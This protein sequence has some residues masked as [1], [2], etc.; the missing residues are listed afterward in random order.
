MASAG[1]YVKKG[2]GHVVKILKDTRLDFQAGMEN[3]Q[4]QEAQQVADFEAS[5]AAYNKA[6]ADLVDAGNRYAAEL[7]SAQLSLVQLETDLKDN[8]DKVMAATNYLAQVGGSCNM[9]IEK[10]GERTKLREA[11]KQAILDAIGVLQTAV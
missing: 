3:L 1:G 8:E 11:E 4:K 9:L 7:Q 2:G 10:F 6:R 5:T